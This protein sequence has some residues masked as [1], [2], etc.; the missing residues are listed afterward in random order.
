[1]S[2]PL[3]ARPNSIIPFG[4]IDGLPDYDY[5]DGASFRVFEPVE[6]APASASVTDQAGL[7][8][9]KCSSLLRG[10][11]LTVKIE[12]RAGRYRV[13]VRGGRAAFENGPDPGY[14]LD[15]GGALEVDLGDP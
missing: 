6:G 5:A 7:T 8:V 14:E 2:L 10:R 1:M 4:A 13:F 12:G 3:L 15:A 9:L 11:R